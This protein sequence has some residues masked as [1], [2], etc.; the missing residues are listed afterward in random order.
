MK[1]TFSPITLLSVGNKRP[2]RMKSMYIVCIILVIFSA[3]GCIF[4]PKSNS[5][6]VVQEERFQGEV[7]IGMT[8]EQ[9]RENWGEPDKIIKRQEKDYDEI[10]IY[11]P[12][13][14]FKNYLY[15]RKGILIKGDPDPENLV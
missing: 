11:I 5:Q 10:W 1:T 7:K 2:R 14:K 12:N 6:N 4:V 3:A 13:W 15:F 8:K 9:I